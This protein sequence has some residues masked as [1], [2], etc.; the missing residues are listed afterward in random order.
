[1]VKAQQNKRLGELTLKDCKDLHG[2][3]LKIAS[4]ELKF[5]NSLSEED[6]MATLISAAGSRHT[7]TIL[8]EKKLFES[9]DKEITFK[10]LLEANRDM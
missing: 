2:F 3:G 9:K 1:M 4:L 8:G 7:T 6:K 5:N 10:A